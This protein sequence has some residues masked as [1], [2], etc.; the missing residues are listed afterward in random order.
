MIKHFTLL[1]VAGDCESPMIGT[2]HN[3]DVSSDIWRLDFRDR[4][5]QAICEHFDIESVSMDPI[6][7]LDEINPFW[8]YELFIQDYGRVTIRILETWLY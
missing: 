5:H 2:I 3:V 1:E 8:D 4:A 7:K 6:P